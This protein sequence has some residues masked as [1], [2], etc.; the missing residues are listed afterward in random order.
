[1][2]SHK[3]D[4]SKFKF[5]CC[6]CLIPKHFTC[7]RSWLRHVKQ[8]HGSDDGD[9]DGTGSS[10]EH[11]QD[12]EDGF[13]SQHDGSQPFQ[14]QTEISDG[15]RFMI[16]SF[17]HSLR[18]HHVPE[19]ACAQVAKS[20]E[21]IGKKIIQE[22]LNGSGDKTCMS[23]LQEFQSNSRYERYVEDHLS[24]VEPETVVVGCKDTGK[25]DSYQ[26]IPLKSQLRH[27]A[28]LPQLH[29]CIFEDEGETS[30]KITDVFDGTAHSQ[31]KK[32]TL[33]LAI[34]YDDFEVANPLGSA[35]GVHKLAALHFSL[36][37]VP[38]EH[39]SK[40]DSIHL[41]VLSLSSV[42]AEY[43]WSVVLKR[44]LDDLKELYTTGMKVNMHGKMVTVYAELLFLPC[45][46]LAVHN[47]AGFVANFSSAKHPCRFC[48]ASPEEFQDKFTEDDFVQRTSDVYQ[49]QLQQVEDSSF[50]AEVISETG[51]KCRCV[52]SELPY[53][54]VTCSFPPDIGHDLL[55]GVVPY[56]LSLVLNKIV[57]VKKYISL[58]ELNELLSAFP[59][60]GRENRPMP[61]RQVKGRIRI[62]QSASQSWVLLRYLPLLLGH[63]IPLDCLEW[64]LLTNLCC[65]VERTFARSFSRGDVEFLK[66]KVADWLQDL[67]CAFPD[68]RLKPKFHY[69]THYGSQIL[70][71][72]PLRYCW[73]MRFESKYSFLKGTIK[74][75]KNF[76]N[77]AR[78]V[79]RKHQLHMAFA[80]H[81]SSYLCSAGVQDFKFMD[82]WAFP[83]WIGDKLQNE[84]YEI[85]H[86]AQID[87]I[88]YV[89]G[90]VVLLSGPDDEDYSFGR[91]CAVC[92]RRGSL[93]FIVRVMTSEYDGMTN[94]YE[95]SPTSEVLT[96][97]RAS[98]RDLCPLHTVTMESGRCVVVLNY[99]V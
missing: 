64:S 73:T 14:S 98:L 96:A 31:R 89:T 82:E 26:Y 80:I 83:T 16:A 2:K 65:I 61:I 23:A 10:S 37:N 21:D 28:S 34:S 69:M 72:G 85:G 12:P 15:S 59:W 17:M 9:G 5:A 25:Q 36:L 56:T 42:V 92:V 81:S 58:A 8:A 51:V 33:Y 4:F 66:F 40:V 39:R 18:K 11:E 7:I 32:N 75:S 71:H 47:I 41:L 90:D 38:V 48:L 91:I 79:S 54:N 24:Y 52:F 30:S 95:V 57:C 97:A 94:S 29:S 49:K 43:G 77:I 87:G 44:L 86:R 62:R 74:E 27:L 45:D 19:T 46:N 76:R 99:H 78:T 35:A 6:L 22:H 53:F 63:Y 93:S 70:K 1:M 3:P 13:T 55:E 67:R 84:G 68:F 60:D 50:Q 88:C 20:V